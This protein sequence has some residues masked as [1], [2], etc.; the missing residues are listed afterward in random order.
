LAIGAVRVEGRSRVFEQPG[1]Q[2]QVGERLGDVVR[3]VG[4]TTTPALRAVAPG[5]P[6]QVEVV[7]Q[8]LRDPAVNYTVFVQLLDITNRPRAQSDREPRAGTAPTSAWVEGEYIVETHE[9]RLPADLA[10]GQ[11]RLVAGMYDSATGVRLP[12]T[13]DRDF[14]ILGTVTIR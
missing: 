8:A 7:W 1:V 9:L 14:A 4:A 12:I 5:G 13:A 2:I 6:L 10:A 11:Y 3:L